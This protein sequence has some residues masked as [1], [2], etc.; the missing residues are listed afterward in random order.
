M[1]FFGS[2]LLATCINSNT[3]LAQQAQ[4]ELGHLQLTILD[5]GGERLACRVHLRDSQDHP[6]GCNLCEAVN[7]GC[8]E[9]EID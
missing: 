7:P 4:A 9:E 3:A 1:V 2:V 6:V 5:E 8:F